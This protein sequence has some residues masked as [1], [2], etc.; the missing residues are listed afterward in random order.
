MWTERGKGQWVF[1][2]LRYSSSL[3]FS[4]FKP[5]S[6]DFP[7]SEINTLT[8]L[9]LSSCLET[10][11]IEMEKKKNKSRL[12]T[13]R[14]CFCCELGLQGLNTCNRCIRTIV[15]GLESVLN[16]LRAQ[17]LLCAWL[18]LPLRAYRLP[19]PGPEIIMFQLL[20]LLLFHSIHVWGK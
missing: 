13:V 18:Q 16:F 4:K 19:W 1:A 6:I 12:N 20:P 7:G 10:L 14:G 9:F 3:N 15:V 11:Y 17:P 8:M 5:S 2:S